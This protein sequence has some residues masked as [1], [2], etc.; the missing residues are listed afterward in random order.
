MMKSKTTIILFILFFLFIIV[1]CRKEEQE[2]LKLDLPIGKANNLVSFDDYNNVEK[3]MKMVDL[4][5]TDTFKSW[6]LNINKEECVN[7][8]LVK[9]WT[10]YKKIEYNESALANHW[11]KYHKESDVD[12]RMVAFL[13]IANH[14]NMSKTIKENGSYL[15]F[16]IDAIDN[17]NNYSILKENKEKFITLFNEIDVKG[18]NKKEIKN[19]YS[20][21]WNEYGI[22]LKNNNVSLINVIMHDNYD[23]VVFVGHSGLLI[24]LNDKLLFVEKIAFEQ[25]YQVTVLKDRSELKNMLF[26]RKNYFGDKTEEG[27][28]IFENDKL[29]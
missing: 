4:D 18:L 15:M 27:P 7:C 28:F 8:G 16:D 21:K 23:N 10:D 25:P 12:C 11:E 3:I 6:V 13:L 22:S 24:D 29:L 2:I 17:V 20:K 19:A 26:A 1:G 5:N 14:I 9:E